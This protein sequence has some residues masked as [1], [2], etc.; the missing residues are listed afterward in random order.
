MIGV[1]TANAALALDAQPAAVL[2]DGGCR[3]VAAQGHRQRRPKR[4]QRERLNVEFRPQFRKV[5]GCFRRF[6]HC[7]RLHVG[8]RGP[9]FLR[10]QGIARDEHRGGQMQAAACFFIERAN[11]GRQIS[12]RQDVSVRARR[13]AKGTLVRERVGVRGAVTGEAPRAVVRRDRK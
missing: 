2:G 5:V 4:H 3:A 10:G 1:P 13:H 9:Q 7:G 12:Q 8:R 11:I 6:G